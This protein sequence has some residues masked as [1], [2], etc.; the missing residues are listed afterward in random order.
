MIMVKDGYVKNRPRDETYSK[1]STPYVR[2][3][4]LFFPIVFLLFSCDSSEMRNLKAEELK[5][6][7]DSGAK[8][9]LVDT[10]SVYEYQTGT[11]SGSINIP[12]EKF[13]RIEQFLPADKDVLIVFFC[14][15]YG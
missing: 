3:L 8:F 2:L 11:I 7:I 1:K 5:Q 9:L 6:M 10:R 13:E 15:G 4:F 12:Q 14:R